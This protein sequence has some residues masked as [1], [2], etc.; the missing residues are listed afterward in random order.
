MAR[1]MRRKHK[2]F[3]KMVEAWGAAEEHLELRHEVGVR[4]MRRIIREL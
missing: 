3:S 4:G 1:V 2:D